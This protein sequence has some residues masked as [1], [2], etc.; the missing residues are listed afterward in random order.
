MTITRKLAVVAVGAGLAA[1]GLLLTQ[2]SSDNPSS[3]AVELISPPSPLSTDAV[4]INAA[5]RAG[6][7]QMCLDGLHDPSAL[8]RYRAAAAAHPTI[9]ADLTED[10]QSVVSSP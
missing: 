9:A 8:A 4:A 1:S 2:A 6:F 3:P 5:T 7:V 10:C